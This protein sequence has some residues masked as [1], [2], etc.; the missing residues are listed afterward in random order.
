VLL[1]VGGV[2]LFVLMLHPGPEV[3]NWVKVWAGT[4]P[5]DEMDV[6]PQNNVRQALSDHSPLLARQTKSFHLRTEIFR[7]EL[8]DESLYQ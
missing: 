7:Q 1:E 8:G 4:R 6:R 3:F 5:L 2:D